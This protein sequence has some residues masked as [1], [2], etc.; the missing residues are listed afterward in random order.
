MNS[1]AAVMNWDNSM[2]LL[3]CFTCSVNLS[4]EGSHLS[5]VPETHC[6]SPLTAKNSAADKLHNGLYKAISLD[7]ASAEQWTQAVQLLC[8]KL[9][10]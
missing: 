3:F 1:S 8:Q 6:A 2:A 5:T 4:D 7:H 10:I 9:D